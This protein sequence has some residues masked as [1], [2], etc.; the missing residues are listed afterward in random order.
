V[1]E[2]RKALNTQALLGFLARIGATA[3][4]MIPMRGALTSMVNRHGKG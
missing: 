3:H 2:V 1:A 4:P